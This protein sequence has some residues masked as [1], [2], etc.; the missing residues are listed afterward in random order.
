MRPFIGPS[1]VSSVVTTVKT[2]LAAAALVGFG[3]CTSVSFHESR[4]ELVVTAV[5]CAAARYVPLLDILGWC[6]EKKV[7][8]R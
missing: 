8:P 7:R 5:S 2:T 3:G 1:S 4:L 6:T